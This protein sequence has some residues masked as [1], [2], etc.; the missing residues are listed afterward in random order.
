MASDETNELHCKLTLELTRYGEVNNYYDVEHGLSRE[1]VL[2]GCIKH[3]TSPFNDKP[4]RLIAYTPSDV[5]RLDAIRD[6]WV[7]GTGNPCGQVWVPAGV[8][9]NEYGE[10][11]VVKLYLSADAFEVIRCQAVEMRD[12]GR[13]MG[14]EIRLVGS[15]LPPAESDVAATLGLQLYNLDTSADQMYGIGG[16]EI[17]GG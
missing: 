16:F 13:F 3:A 6:N 8:E 10:A 4:V 15:A 9:P 1:L 14:A 17:V 11:V 7:G 5:E 2:L 12:L